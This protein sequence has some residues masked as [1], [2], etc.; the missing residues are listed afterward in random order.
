MFVQAGTP[1]TARNC[2]T[3]E[4]ACESKAMVGMIFVEN[5]PRVLNPW[6]VR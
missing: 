3:K 4:M 6:R 1:T 2:Y 5:S